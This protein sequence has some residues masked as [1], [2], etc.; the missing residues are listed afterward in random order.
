MP[1]KSCG[2][3]DHERSSSR[4]CP[5]YTPRPNKKPPD[6]GYVKSDEKVFKIGFRE[7]CQKQYVD[8]IESVVND[9]VSRCTQIAY[10]ASLLL[11]LHLQRCIENMVELPKD[12]TSQTYLRQYFIAVQRD[13]TFRLEESIQNTFD[14]FYVPCR[15]KD[16]KAANGKSCGQILTYLVKEYSTN[17]E[18]HINQRFEYAYLQKLR[19]HLKNELGFDKHKAYDLIQ[20]ITSDSID[21]R[22]EFL[23]ENP[24]MKSYVEDYHS[25]ARSLNEKLKF[26][27]HR[28][29][30][31]FELS[32]K[33][34][35]NKKKKISTLVPIYDF[36][37][38]YITLDTDVLYE[39]FHY[40]PLF[41]GLQKK[42]FGLQQ[43]VVFSTLFKIPKKLM[44]HEKDKR[45]FNYMIKTDGVGASVVTAKWIEKDVEISQCETKEERIKIYKQRND[46]RL[47]KEETHLLQ[48]LQKE[49]CQL[50]GIDPGKNDVMTSINEDY[51]SYSVSNKRYYTESRFNYRTDKVKV[52]ERQYNLHKWL[53]QIPSL[54]GS[55]TVVSLQ[56]IKYVLSQRFK[57]RLAMVTSRKYK[58]LRW[59]VYIE[60]QKTVQRF[61][62]EIV[63][64]SV[65][66]HLIVFFG[67]AKF[68][69]ALKGTASSPKQARFVK[70]LRNMKVNVYMVNEFNTSLVC[71]ECKSERRLVDCNTANKPY[72]VRRCTEP[73]CRMIWNRD[74][75]AAGNILDVGYHMLL[76]K[77]RPSVFSKRLPTDKTKES[78][79]IERTSAK[80]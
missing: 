44:Y 19:D 65:P 50:I 26:L 61:C 10:E 18:L 2:N 57:D 55:T 48:V 71:N 42:T 12:I 67:D 80:R 38:K 21:I 63:A 31:L 9:A 22:D 51:Q 39:L 30:Q 79:D 46:D 58:K 47:K 75:N 16:F 74:V 34:D 62:K 40:L 41:S 69:H 8:I 59:K 36:K 68:N 32:Q 78:G 23:K 64:D 60:N 4:S 24:N 66:E 5:N 53:L 14:N 73:S 33:Q 54:K 49:D 56:Y 29:V 27:Y 15:D 6:K 43:D 52:Y 37:S 76:H 70:Q 11:M 72:T 25:C 35:D 7:L 20:Q 3:A 28:S 1:C 13:N 77:K 17:L 45:L